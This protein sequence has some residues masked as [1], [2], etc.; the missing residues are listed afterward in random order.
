MTI[1]AISKD[2]INMRWDVAV[3]FSKKITWILCKMIGQKSQY[4]RSYNFKLWRYGCI[5]YLYE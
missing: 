1:R 5:Q 3:V 2:A 4:K